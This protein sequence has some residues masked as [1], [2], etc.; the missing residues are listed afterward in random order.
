MKT[1]QNE[2]QVSQEILNAIKEALDNNWPELLRSIKIEDLRNGLKVLLA[3]GMFELHPATISLLVLEEAWGSWYIPIWSNEKKKYCNLAILSSC[4]DKGLPAM[5]SWVLSRWTDLAKKCRHEYSVQGGERVERDPPRID[6]LNFN[7]K[8]VLNAANMLWTRYLTDDCGCMA[9]WIYSIDKA[10]EIITACKSKKGVGGHKFTPGGYFWPCHGTV[11]DSLLGRL[12]EEKKLLFS[13]M[14]NIENLKTDFTNST[15]SSLGTISREVP[16]YCIMLAIFAKLIAET[17]ECSVLWNKDDKRLLFS[18]FVHILNATDHKVEFPFHFHLDLYSDSYRR[19]GRT[20]GRSGNVADAIV[21]GEFNNEAERQI[22]LMFL[23]YYL[24]QNRRDATVMS[25]IKANDAFEDYFG[26]ERVASWATDF[27]LNE[28]K[29]SNKDKQVKGNASFNTVEKQN[30]IPK[31][32]FYFREALQQQEKE[33][34]Y[35]FGRSPF[36]L[37]RRL[38][39]AK[40]KGKRS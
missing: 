7:F 6:F 10:I 40:K 3:S 37:K 35:P 9:R 32:V 2:C 26:K 29:K 24:Q 12:G 36:I 11:R 27:K 21:D 5:K 15:E 22:L 4:D 25:A 13:S 1:T 18:L 39:N 33:C 14:K 30:S 20:N 8:A 31:M 19:L 38:Q 16:R 17:A 34:Y 28:K 23:A